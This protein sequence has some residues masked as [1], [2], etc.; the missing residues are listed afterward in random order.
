MLLR[1][2]NSGS[3]GTFQLFGDIHTRW[4]MV[5]LGWVVCLV[6]V[7]WCGVGRVRVPLGK[8]IH[9]LSVRFSDHCVN[10]VLETSLTLD[11]QEVQVLWTAPP[12]GSGCVVF[13]AAVMERGELWSSDGRLKL[14]LCDENEEKEEV[15]IIQEDCCACQEAKYEIMLQVRI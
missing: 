1:Q 3:G 9:V 7:V 15:N 6:C 5:R 13:Q 14:V 8:L 11:K 10:T 12:S 4:V 2:S